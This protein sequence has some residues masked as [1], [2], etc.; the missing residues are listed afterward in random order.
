MRLVHTA[1]PE[2]ALSTARWAWCPGFDHFRK[3]GNMPKYKQI[4]NKSQVRICRV[5]SSYGQI[6][7]GL[8]GQFYPSIGEGLPGAVNWRA[9]Q[10]RRVWNFV[11]LFISFKSLIN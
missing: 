10:S 2:K 3:I 4:L 7:G 5:A 6:T 9:L 11:K 8:T 1:P